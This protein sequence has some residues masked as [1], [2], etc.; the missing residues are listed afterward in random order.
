MVAVRG[1][2][3]ERKLNAL[4]CR[5]KLGNQKGSSV[6]RNSMTKGP[7]TTTSLLNVLFIIFIKEIPQNHLLNFLNKRN[8]PKL[9]NKVTTKMSYARLKSVKS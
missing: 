5:Q 4:E 8:F 6:G 9:S 1:V 7:L 2:G 3:L